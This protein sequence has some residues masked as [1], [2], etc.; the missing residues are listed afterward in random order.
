MKNKDK[1]V[2]C[3]ARTTGK[4]PVVISPWIRDLGI[5]KR[6]SRFLKCNE[7]DFGFFS[8]RYSAQEMSKIYSG[9]RNE[10]YLKVRNNWEPW[11]SESYNSNHDSTNWIH[12]RKVGIE[13]FLIPIIGETELTIA[14]IGGDTGQF[15]P[16]FASKKFVVDPSSK[17]PVSGVESVIDFRDLPEVDLIIYAHVLEHVADP[18]LEINTLF[19]KASK[20]YIE[21]PFGVPRITPSRRSKIRFFKKVLRTLHPLFWKNQT[22][23]SSGRSGNSQDTLTQSEHLNFF[24]EEAIKQLSFRVSAKVEIQRAQIETPDYMK[25]EVLQCLLIKLNESEVPL[26]PTMGEK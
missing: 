24:S 3:G 5:K 17:I 8:Y 26:L 4:A 2:L 15:I 19:L 12:S 21:V 20:V 10:A 14:D 1:C 16:D 11:Y 23:P 7:C 9:Y 13:K 18:V 25:A 22:R 6:T